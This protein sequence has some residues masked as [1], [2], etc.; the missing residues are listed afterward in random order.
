MGAAAYVGRVGGLAVALGVG[1]AVATGQGVAS[2][3]PTDSASPTSESTTQES[4]PD[5]T[6]DTN[7]TD[8]SPESEVSSPETASEKTPHDALKS[9]ANRIA[10]LGKV[11]STGGA[12][13]SKKVTKRTEQAKSEKAEEA[14][15]DEDAEVVDPEESEVVAPPA[16]TW[17]P[18]AITDIGTSNKRSSSRPADKPVEASISRVSAPEPAVDVRAVDVVANKNVVPN[19]PDDTV[20]QRTASTVES[21][22]FEALSFSATVQEPAVAMMAAPEAPAAKAPLPQLVTNV[23]SA[24]GLGSLASDVPGVPFGSGAAL[25]LLAYGSRRETEQTYA[26][27]AGPATSGTPVAAAALTSAPPAAAVTAAAVTPVRVSSNTDF[28]EYVTGTNTRYNTEQRFG[29][30]GTD[31]GIMWDNGTKD[32]PAT[33][34]VNEHQV[35]IAFGDTFS[36]DVPVR[37]GDLADEHAVPHLRQQLVRRHEC[38][39]GHTA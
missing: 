15:V 18:P 5:T 2:A 7:P 20:L 8:T 6:P 38:A 33:T 36:Q 9:A 22:T 11:L 27:L 3:S 1:A 35:L 14:V 29:I 21:A 31:L 24:F 28:I 39:G 37:T 34:D 13:T 17:T 10:E 12:L 4:G 23:L 26:A 30:G 25:A 19:Q 16:P 32:N